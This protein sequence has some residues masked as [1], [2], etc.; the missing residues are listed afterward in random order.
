[1]SS[2]KHKSDATEGSDKAAK[3][4]RVRAEIKELQKQWRKVNLRSESFSLPAWDLWD[5]RPTFLCRKVS[6]LQ[7]FIKILTADLVTSIAAD[8][9]PQC[10][11]YISE[12]LFSLSLCKIY[13]SLAVWIRIYGAQ[14]KRGCIP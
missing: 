13:K 7:L 12:S 1:M 10:L 2:S 9:D 6:L 14:R 4:V 5:R 11:L 3:Q 8:I